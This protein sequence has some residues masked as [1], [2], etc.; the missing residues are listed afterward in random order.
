VKRMRVAK[1]ALAAQ[2][3]CWAEDQ[4]NGLLRTWRAVYWTMGGGAWPVPSRGIG[5]R[6]G[7]ECDFAKRTH[8][9]YVKSVV[10][11]L[12]DQSKQAGSGDIHCKRCGATRAGH[13][14]PR[15]VDHG[16]ESCR[17]TS[18]INWGRYY[19]RTQIQFERWKGFRIARPLSP[20]VDVEISL[21]RGQGI[22]Y[23]VPVLALC[24]FM[25]VWVDPLSEVGGSTG[26]GEINIPTA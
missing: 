13:P 16:K 5:E 22:S 18:R 10:C 17:V 25:L 20:A 3:L 12:W 23:S 26:S 4:N 24:P 7:Q 1:T 9:G 8:L 6:K 11:I 19:D 14:H 21:F 2:L 15:N